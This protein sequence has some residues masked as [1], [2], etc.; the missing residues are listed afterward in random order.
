MR[1]VGLMGASEGLKNFY[2]KA[3]SAR[4]QCFLGLC[5]TRPWLHLLTL[6][7]LLF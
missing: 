2:K 5:L 3:R 7:S 4:S 1:D 6:D